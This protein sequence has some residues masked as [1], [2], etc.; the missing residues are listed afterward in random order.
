MSRVLKW[1]KRVLFV[2]LA[3]LAALA[4]VAAVVPV[5]TDALPAPAAYGAGA[6]SVKPSYSGLQREFPALN[7]P[8]DNPSTP[9]K[10]ELGRLLFFDPVLS[11]GNDT[12]C[13]TCH[14][15]DYGFGDGLPRA[16]GAGGIG[17]GLDRQGGKELKRSAPS[18]WNAGYAKVLFWD[19]RAKSLEEQARVPLTHPDEMASDPDTLVA[20]L[21]AIPVYV[22]L[23]DKAFGGGSGAVTF[24]NIQRAVGAFQRTLISDDS[25]FD[26]YAA[27]QF[28]A[29]TPAQRR[30]LAL[31]RSA[32]TRCFECHAAPTFAGD[33]FLV[34]GVPDAPDQPHDA[35]RADVAPG[36]QDGAFKTPSL[37]NIALTAPYMH[38]G[39]FKTL[40]EVVD[41]YAKGGGREYGI[42]N[43][44]NF[45]LGFDLSAQEK[46]DLVAFLF[47][48]T[49][50]SK[51]PAIPDSV[52]SGLPVVARLTNP[53]RDIVAKFNA[54][55]SGRGTSSVLHTPATI[56][57]EPAMTI[58][59][60]VD[61]AQ[62][63][64][65]IE[66]PY[67]VYTE[68]VVVDVSNMTLRGLPNDTGEWPILDGDGKLADG[69]IA[70]GNTFE[71]ANFHIRNYTDNGVLVEG[72][73]GVH[74]HD[75]FVENTGVYGV[76]PVQSTDVLIERVTAT[77]VNDAGIYAGKCEKVIIRDSVAYG[78]V[79]GIEVENTVTAEVY[80]NHA[81]DNALGIFVDLLP[82]LPSK[83]SLYTKVYGNV[84]ENNNRE[85]FAPSTT[86]A[87]KVR[88]GTGILLLASDHVEVYGNTLRG[89]KTAGVAVFNLKVGFDENEIDVGPNPEHNWVHDNVFENNGYDADEFVKNLVGS[90]YDI[91]WDGSGWNNRFDQPGARTF[92]PVLPGSDWAAPFYNLYWRALNFVV[93]LLV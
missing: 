8:D 67:G 54:A 48:L 33:T 63:G 57:L 70:S 80:H 35:G 82:Q 58:Q 6:S 45:V 76:Y 72:A 39:V 5:P 49:D 75:L 13:A 55:P 84:S 21:R 52:P 41:F 15:P 85:N 11:A 56:T 7:E 60:A 23:F 22:A 69:V 26:R 20:E 53:A 16:I 42:Q 30:G 61:R 93:G 18:L 74:L 14:H 51:L 31:F 3:G 81:Y 44:D 83:V 38:N 37:R 62:P 68:R 9:D 46:A 77:G 64:D 24:E 92:P 34:T 66:V 50:E 1:A 25:P 43:V 78:N 2:L 12:A 90:G 36:G 71:L 88:T 40:E 10:V 27:G 79:I 65:T 73:T 89:N 91:L 59:S 28:D 29:L 4:I 87:A 19:G 47:A 86:N 32:A 17:I